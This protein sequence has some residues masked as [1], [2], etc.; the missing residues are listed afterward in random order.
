MNQTLAIEGKVWK[1][2]LRVLSLITFF[3]GAYTLVQS[4]LELIS[5]FEAKDVSMLVVV[6]YILVTPLCFVAALFFAIS[7][8]KMAMGE[9]GEQKIVLAYAVLVLSAVDNLIYVSVHHAG[10]AISFYLLAGIELVCFVVL[11]LYYQGWGIRMLAL[12][13]AI[14]LIACTALELEEAVRYFATAEAVVLQDWIGYYFSQSV[15]SFL[16]ALQSLLFLFG[17]KKE[18]PVK[19]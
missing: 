14:L 3:I 1:T 2:V 13:S 11:F 8:H 9:E 16:I 15:L 12:S 10:D 17:L 6:L 19:K 5:Y 18:I 7:V 4:V